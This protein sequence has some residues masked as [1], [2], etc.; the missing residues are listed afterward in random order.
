MSDEQERLDAQIDDVL[1]GR[2]GPAVDP[3]VLWLASAARPGP[4]PALRARIDDQVAATTVPRRR[5]DRPGR[6]LTIV[7]A[8]LAAAFV[9]QGVGNLV[10]GE[11]ISENIGEPFGPHAFFEGGLAMLAAAVCAAAAT[12]R[13][14]WSTLSVLTC[15]PLALSLGLHGTGEIGVFAA[16]V[17]LHLTEG[18]LGLLLIL[19]WWLDRRDTGRGPDED[20]T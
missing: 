4:S 13:R 3:T 9:F 5:T 19:A 7:A 16:G 12:A 8:A 10:A 14:S 1:D 18:A 6:L 11:W 17:A 20:G 2:G 15:A